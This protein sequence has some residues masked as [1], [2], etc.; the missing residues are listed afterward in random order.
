MRTASSLTSTGYIQLLL[1]LDKT[2][3]SKTE[4]Y[5]HLTDVTQQARD[6]TFGFRDR[7]SGSY[8]AGSAGFVSSKSALATST[9]RTLVAGVHVA[10]FGR[11]DHLHRVTSFVDAARRN[12]GTAALEKKPK[13][14]STTH[15][16]FIIIIPNK[17]WRCTPDLWNSDCRF[18]C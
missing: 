9:G 1:R 7:L 12:Q 16:R 10:W 2:N 11:W 15:V 8:T 17:T 3:H 13:Q 18:Y 5:Q 14:S 6:V 4:S